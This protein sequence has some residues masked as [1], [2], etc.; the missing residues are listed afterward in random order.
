MG[1]NIR[2][3]DMELGDGHMKDMFDVNTQAAMI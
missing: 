1:Y 3:A 2:D